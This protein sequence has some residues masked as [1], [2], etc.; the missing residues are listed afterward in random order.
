MICPGALTRWV[1]PSLSGLVLGSGLVLLLSL[2]YYSALSVAAY[3]CLSLVLLGLGSKLYVHLMGLLKK[4]CK[5]P[6]LAVENLDVSLTEEQV[7]AVL[8]QAAECYNSL[9]AKLKSLL[10]V[11]NALDSLKFSLVLYSCTLLGSLAN[12]LSLLTLAWLAFFSLPSLYT[13]KQKELDSLL[14]T[15][16]GH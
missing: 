2:S 3:F 15:I 9:A 5:D 4:P 12:T 8:L 10:L 16:Q 1:D 7:S 6:L 14:A 13:A 11:E